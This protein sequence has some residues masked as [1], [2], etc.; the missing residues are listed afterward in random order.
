MT[1]RHWA[2]FGC[3]LAVAWIAGDEWSRRHEPV[4]TWVDHREMLLA[5]QE[6]LRTY[7]ERRRLGTDEVEQIMR[8]TEHDWGRAYAWEAMVDFSYDPYL[9]QFGVHAFDRAWN[10]WYSEVLQRAREPRLREGILQT[11]GQAVFRLLLHPTWDDNI[12][13]RV[14]RSHGKVLVLSR[15][16]SSLGLLKI[17]VW[18]PGPGVL[19]E[20]GRVELKSWQAAELERFLA[21]ADVLNRKDAVKWSIKD[22]EI[23]LFEASAEGRYNAFHANTLEHETQERE[24]QPL[25]DLCRFL[26]L[27]SGLRRPV[28]HGKRVLLAQE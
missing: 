3:L 16:V 24:L 1:W 14:E 5:N 18:D 2:A 19:L 25:V 26:I 27:H 8:E 22:G 28:T 11:P 21:E 12:V 13:I 7:R 9:P 4:E 6:A 10:F 20:E 15:R 23:W 17:P